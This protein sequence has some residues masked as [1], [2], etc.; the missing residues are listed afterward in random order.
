MT[1]Y[2]ERRVLSILLG[3]PELYP[4]GLSAEDFKYG[5]HREIFQALATTGDLTEMPLDDEVKSY[6]LDLDEDYAPQNLGLFANMVKTRANL[7]RFAES[8]RRLR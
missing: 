8:M 5:F 3:R 6:M 2:A 4:C 1:N 7:R